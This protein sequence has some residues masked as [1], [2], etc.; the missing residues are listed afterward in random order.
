[1]VKSA[2]WKALRLARESNFEDGVYCEREYGFDIYY[3]I[4]EGE[5]LLFQSYDKL[6]NDV[7]ESNKDVVNS[8]MKKREDKGE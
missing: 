3:Y 8:H 1:M 2:A 5:R 4:G 7:F 6:L